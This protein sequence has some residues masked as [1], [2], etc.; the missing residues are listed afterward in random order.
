MPCGELG[1]RVAISGC[2]ARRESLV[3]QSHF[4]MRQ[5]D[6]QGAEERDAGIVTGMA[7][8]FVVYGGNALEYLVAVRVS[9]GDKG[10]S[11]AVLEHLEVAGT[12]LQADFL[13]DG[14]VENPACFI[15]Y[16][17]VFDLILFLQPGQ[18]ALHLI[19]TAAHHRILD[20]ALERR[21]KEDGVLGGD[22]RNQALLM[23][24]LQQGDRQDEQ[25]HNKG[26]RPE[27]FDFE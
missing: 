17:Q 20:G 22:L 5:I 27:Y 1:R 18:D 21:G 2:G 25:D 16:P 15:K 23:L 9:N 19:G 10:Y 6:L 3:E 7:C 8:L 11:P 4:A 13:L 12:D 26:Y 14:R 24:V